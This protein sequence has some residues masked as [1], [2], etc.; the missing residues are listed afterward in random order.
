MIKDVATWLSAIVCLVNKGKII[1][2]IVIF[3]AANWQRT[4]TTTMS[5]D[6]H[7]KTLNQARSQTTE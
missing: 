4:K 7:I 6:K 2:S 1:L 5:T 3:N